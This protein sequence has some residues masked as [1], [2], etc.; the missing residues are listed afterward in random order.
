MKYAESDTQRVTRKANISPPIPK[1]QLVNYIQSTNPVAENRFGSPDPSCV[2]P[3][4]VGYLCNCCQVSQARGRR[5][6]G[7]KRKRREEEGRGGKGEK[8]RR[9][10]RRKRKREVHTNEI[11]QQPLTIT[12]VPQGYPVYIPVLHGSLHPPP[13]PQQTGWYNPYS[14][15]VYPSYASPKVRRRKARKAKSEDSRR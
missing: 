2:C 14:N 6:R 12:P 13:L 1:R 5:G 8:E 15:V 10:K 9:R 4:N 7:E 3:V 11:F